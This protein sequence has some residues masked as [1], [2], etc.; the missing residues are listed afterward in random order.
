M[1][2]T[3]HDVVRHT[4]FLA[5]NG[6]PRAASARLASLRALLLLPLIVTAANSGATV[7]ANTSRCSVGALSSVAPTNTTITAASVVGA[8]ATVPQYCSVQATVA[9]PGN[10]IDFIVGFPTTWNEHFVWASQ[11]GLA[12]QTM[13][14]TASFLQEG[15]ATGITDTGHKGD[16]A[17]VG[18]MGRDPAFAYDINKLTD[19]GHRA[20]KL[21]ADASKTLIAGYY[22]SSIKRSIF[23]GCS[24]GGRSVMINAQRYPGQ[25]DAYVIGAPFISETGSSLDWLHSERAYFAKTT[26]F[27]PA[28]KLQLVGK[29]VLAACDADDGVVDGVV[30]NPLACKFDPGVLQCSGADAPNCLTQDQVTA[31]R[32]WN[33][34]WKNAS[35]EVVSRR[36]LATGEEGFPSGTSL[37]QI[38]PNPAPVDASGVPYP[39]AAQN[40]GYSLM[41]GILGDMVHGNHAYD[42]RTLNINTDLPFL[43]QVNGVLD[44][45]DTDL[46]GAVSK[47][48]KFIFYQGWG[49][50]ALNPLNLIDYRNAVVQRYGQAKAD[51]FMRV[52]M[53]PG[54]NHCSGGSAAT[55]Q[56]DVMMPQIEA[57]MDTGVAPEVVPAS[58]VAN[59][60]VTRT[61]PL[62]A[63]PK[64]ARYKA[65]ASA[66]STFGIEDA[67]YFYCADPS[68]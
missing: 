60:V 47:G 35:G 67:S 30:S 16:A 51:S 19:Y 38:G 41:I 31:V 4:A 10:N 62:C 6:R 33:T 50:P 68:P 21:T 43:A 58:R 56:F 5:L 14:F 32:F 13:T 63:Y 45:T 29:A 65:P 9:Y 37:Y 55:D 17:A 18:G 53:V 27:M 20:N 34:D 23:N 59:A 8:T 61:R 7:T 1:F 54:M 12:G 39:T 26:S 24:N 42:Y 11:G 40:N 22:Q 64:Y 48:A 25:F 2:K 28:A 66:A 49:D 15:Y 46:M 36:W 52:F 57:W 44:G 3:A